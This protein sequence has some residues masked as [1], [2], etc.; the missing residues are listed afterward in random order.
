M[1]SGLQ[2]ALPVSFILPCSSLETGLQLLLWEQALLLFSPRSV[3][4]VCVGAHYLLLRHQLRVY[5]LLCSFPAAQASLV[6]ADK[7]L[8]LGTWVG[9]W[10]VSVF[11]SPPSFFP[12]PHYLLQARVKIQHVE[13]AAHPSST[14]QAGLRAP[15]DPRTLSAQP[16]RL[17]PGTPRQT[18]RPTAELLAAGPSWAI[19]VARRWAATSWVQTW[20]VGVVVP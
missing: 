20:G 2:Q 17:L 12:L 6:A 10:G 9:G 7:V 11:P 4:R 3:Q 13:T 16:C 8:C 15:S 19:P 5:S 14:V 1:R 18:P